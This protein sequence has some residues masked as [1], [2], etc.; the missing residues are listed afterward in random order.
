M[1]IHGPSCALTACLSRQAVWQ[2]I[3]LC[4][5]FLANN[6]QYANNHPDQHCAYSLQDAGASRAQP[7]APPLS[8]DECAPSRPTFLR[9]VAANSAARL[10]SRR[11]AQ[12]GRW[13]ALHPL[14]LAAAGSSHCLLTS[15]SNSTSEGGARRVLVDRGGACVLGSRSLPVGLV[16]FIWCNLIVG[17]SP[18]RLESATPRFFKCQ[19]PAPPLLVSRLGSLLFL[20]P[21]PTLVFRGRPSFSCACL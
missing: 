8:A 4:G 13:A 14:L 7:R 10:G 6:T 2:A 9:R 5:V 17:S 12:K 15:G 16:H 18:F 11:L 1:N 3:K 19:L 20:H 21:G